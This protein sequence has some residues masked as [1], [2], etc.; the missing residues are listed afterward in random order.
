MPSEVFTITSEQAGGTL[1]KLLR[2]R[3][4]DQS[5][6]AVRR[7][8][9]TRR[10]RVGGDLCLDPARRLKEGEVFEL[11]EKPLARP[12]HADELHIRHLDEH[13]VVVEKPSGQ[14][15]VRHPSERDWTPQRRALA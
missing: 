13:V 10:V 1:A 8:V 7:V 12:R 2:D 9:E 3:L 14:P 15:T 4:P 11:L 6:N 5:W